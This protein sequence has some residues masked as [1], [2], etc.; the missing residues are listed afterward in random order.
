[1]STIDNVNL[2]SYGP[3]MQEA[4]S[5]L[6]RGLGAVM[7]LIGFMTSHARFHISRICRDAGYAL[8]PE[9]ADTLMLIRHFN[10]LTQ[11]RLA[12]I[13]GKDKAAITRLMN[14]LVKSGLVERAQDLQ[15]RRVI[16]AQITAEGERAFVQVWPEITRLSDLALSGISEA[17]LAA[18]CRTLAAI[19]AN[20][21]ELTGQCN[22]SD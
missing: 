22:Q 11:S 3:P 21:C 16:R 2:L 6:N 9:E 13:L 8:T 4:R 18:L 7:P 20:L 14:S 10:G 15:D 17:E 19:N 5:E 1:M 12:Q